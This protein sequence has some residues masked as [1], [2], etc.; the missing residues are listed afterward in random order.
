MEKL[1][2]MGDLTA[3][4]AI[5]VANGKPI[6]R[7]ILFDR[8]RSE[9]LR[10]LNGQLKAYGNK[11]IDENGS[12]KLA[13]LTNN[14][15]D[16]RMTDS[17]TRVL[18]RT[19][20]IY[21]A[22][23]G[24]LIAMGKK[25][26]KLGKFIEHTNSVSEIRYVFETGNAQGDKNVVLAINHG[27]TQDG[28]PLI[29]YNEDG[30]NTI[31]VLVAKE[32]NVDIIPTLP[33]HGEWYLTDNKFGIPIGEPVSNPFYHGK[34]ND[35]SPQRCWVDH[36]YPGYVGQLT[37]GFDSAMWPWTEYHIVA[38]PPI[39]G[40]RGGLIAKLFEPIAEAAEN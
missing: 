38:R 14:E 25:D 7:V 23:T 32:A 2:R 40:L 18:E 15:I 1:I 6:N 20:H 31:L 35:N 13:L 11:P 34:M 19:A 8:R 9:F 16:E 4:Q 36:Y 37:R 24:T 21:P 3:K 27:F 5:D 26:E 33:I 39:Y 29:S 10:Y 12:I 28:K 30:K 17:E 22:W